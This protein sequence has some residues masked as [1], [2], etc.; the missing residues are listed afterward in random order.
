[1]R[2]N[3]EKVERRDGALQM[4]SVVKSS[5]TLC[6]GLHESP[7]SEWPS[8]PKEAYVLVLGLVEVQDSSQRHDGI[9]REHAK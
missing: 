4:V 7:G 8:S 3:L 2:N 6:V 9:V 1:M 5:L